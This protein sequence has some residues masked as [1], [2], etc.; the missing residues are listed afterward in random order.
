MKC[1]NKHI[2]VSRQFVHYNA[3]PIDVFQ[4]FNKEDDGTSVESG[5]KSFG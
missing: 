4:K 3:R 1:C 2:D 5:T